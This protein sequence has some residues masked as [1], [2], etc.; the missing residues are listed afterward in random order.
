MLKNL[1]L[2]VFTRVFVNIN[3]LLYQ[4]MHVHK[5]LDMCRTCDYRLFH[6]RYSRKS[7]GLDQI[8]NVFARV[9]VHLY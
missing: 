5:V 8:V 1:Y 4:Y 6:T 2:N 3:K 7:S 9:F